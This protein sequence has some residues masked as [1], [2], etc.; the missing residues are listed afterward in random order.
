MLYTHHGAGYG[1]TGNYNEYFN[2]NLDKDSMSYLMMAC[3][4]AKKIYK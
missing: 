3:R 2:E 4:L 1:F